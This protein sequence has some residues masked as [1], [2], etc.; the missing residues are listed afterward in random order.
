MA[1]DPPPIDAAYGKAFVDREQTGQPGEANQRART[2]RG[3][4]EPRTRSQ[5][6]THRLR[7]CPAAGR[8]A[9]VPVLHAGVAA[10]CDRQPKL[11]MV[12]RRA[13]GALDHLRTS[14]HARSGHTEAQSAVPVLELEVLWP[15]SGP[16]GALAGLRPVS[17]LYRSCHRAIADLA[18]EAHALTAACA[19]RLVSTGKCAVSAS[20]TREPSPRG[21]IREDHDDGEPR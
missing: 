8:S 19:E 10:R 7:C 14:G 17:S 11:R 20:R 3:E 9:A 12:R 1:V 6:R 4:H 5:A 15:I 21:P 16:N 2:G 13:A 18:S